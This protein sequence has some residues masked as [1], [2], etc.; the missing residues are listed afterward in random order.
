MLINPKL[1]VKSKYLKPA[2]V[3]KSVARVIITSKSQDFLDL[4]SIR[5]MNLAKTRFIVDNSAGDIIKTELVKNLELIAIDPET[6]YIIPADD[7][8]TEDLSLAA[9]PGAPGI[10]PPPILYPEMGFR[11]WQPDGLS[12]A[13]EGR[14]QYLGEGAGY[15]FG[16]PATNKM[17]REVDYLITPSLREASTVAKGLINKG[18]YLKAVV[19]LPTNRTTLK[20][21][22]LPGP[23]SVQSFL[24]RI[25]DNKLLGNCDDDVDSFEEWKRR[26]GPPYAD[27][28]L[29]TPKIGEILELD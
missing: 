4:E 16:D 6:C 21:G 29:Y 2:D 7:D 3:H 27:I 8:G 26:L 5:G 1:S 23:L 24:E 20:L 10:L 25:I 9:V 15:D 19:R 18:G 11:V 13:Y 28:K 12:V 22:E 14:G 17:L